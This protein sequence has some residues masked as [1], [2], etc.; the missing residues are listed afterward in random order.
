MSNDFLW[1]Q[2]APNNIRQEVIKV[3][4]ICIS[5]LSSFV[6]TTLCFKKNKKIL[7]INKTPFSALLG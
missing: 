2:D 5:H 6:C 3:W 1:W 7:Y 4:G